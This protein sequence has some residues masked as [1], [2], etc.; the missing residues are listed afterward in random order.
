MARNTSNRRPQPHR[1]CNRTQQRYA[2]Q[3]LYFE[4]SKEY[5][6]LVCTEEHRSYYYV[7][8][9]I[10]DTN[11]VEKVLIAD[12]PNRDIQIFFTPSLARFLGY[13]D[14][15]HMKEDKPHF[16]YWAKSCTKE[17][18][19]AHFTKSTKPKYFEGNLPNM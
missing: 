15:A 13:K 10:K 7:S 19:I 2:L 16:R 5:W 12:Q 14:L 8:A 3:R 11:K 17:T 9:P 18:I 6:E 4:R 1:Y